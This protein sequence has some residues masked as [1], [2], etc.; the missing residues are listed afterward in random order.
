MKVTQDK[1]ESRQAYLTIELD[2]DEVEKGMKKAYNRLVQ[3][4]NIPGF[5]KGKAPRTL[6]TRFLDDERMQEE[7]LGVMAGAGDL[8]ELRRL[9]PAIRRIHLR[10][11]DGLAGA[12]PGEMVVRRRVSRL[13]YS[14]RSPEASAVAAL[15]ALGAPLAP[16]MEIGY[17]V[18][19]ADRWFVEVEGG[20][21][22]GDFD[23]GYYAHLLEKAWDEVAFTLDRVGAETPAPNQGADRL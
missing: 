13:S 1:I 2:S 21:G 4:A 20:G 8:A 19:D 6:L 5:R 12:D 9:D 16:G 18:T 23:R 15:R 11:A 3:K 17:V 14:R 22:S 10:Y 7:I